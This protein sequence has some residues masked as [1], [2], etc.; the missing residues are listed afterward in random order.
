VSRNVLVLNHFAVPRSAPGG[1]RHVELFGRLSGWSAVILVSNRNML[2]RSRVDDDDGV[3]SVWTTP[4]SPSG[5][6]RILNWVSYAV[7]AFAV[8]LRQRTDLVYASSPHLLAGVAGWAIAR[9]KRVP[10]IVEVR[11]LWP[12]VLVDMGQMSATS[13]QFVVLKRIERFLYRH[14]DAVVVL[15]EGST[16]AVVADGADPARVVFLPNGAEPSDF[17]VTEDRAVLRERFGMEGFV[18]VYAGAHGRAN[19]LELVL[20]AAEELGRDGSE[21]RFWLVGDGLLK[22]LL[23]EDAKRRGLDNVVFRDPVAKHEVPALLAAADAG[24]HVLAD[25]P[26]FRH[27]VSPNKLFDYMA[28]GRP[29]LTNTPGDVTSMVNL[30]GSGL[31]VEPTGLASGAAKLAAMGPDELLAMGANGRRFMQEHRSREVVSANLER[32][33]DDTRSRGRKRGR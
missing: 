32:L 18:L 4:Y 2:T 7:T 14:A 9:I 19:G 28:A 22:Q 13:R 25:V 29:V 1:T 27:G 23:T 24:L 31:A 21:V 20:D 6:S 11:D 16:A 8:G 15:A 33:L 17:D 12:A 10:L 5:I 3:R 26:L 30:A